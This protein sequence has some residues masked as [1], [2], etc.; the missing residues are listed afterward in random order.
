M[1]LIPDLNTTSGGPTNVA[2]VYERLSS[3]LGFN[4]RI[5]ETSTEKLNSIKS[6][7]LGDSVMLSHCIWDAY[8][9]IYFLR[10]KSRYVFS[11]GMLSKEAFR[12]VSIK[13]L[14][15]FRLYLLAIERLRVT[16][17][18]G[19]R[20]EFQQA[21]YKPRR[22]VILS[23]PVS[24]M[25]QSS[26][27]NVTHFR[28]GKVKFVYFSRFE[29]RKGLLE[30]LTAFHLLNSDN[31]EFHIIG[32]KSDIGYEQKIV[33]AAENM[34]NVF[35]HTGYS[36]EAA[37]KKMQC[38]DVICLWS[39]FEGQ[40]MSIIEGVADGLLPLVSSD[41]NLPFPT[42]D[43]FGFNSCKKSSDLSELME[44]FS[45]L[46][47]RQIEDVRKNYLTAINTSWQPNKDAQEFLMSL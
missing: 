26:D 33:A 44:Y 34:P 41:C 12:K 37:R 30:L 40:P 19:S 9:Y 7:N 4:T 1:Q 18:F 47:R 36:G 3:E 10:C 23:N 13:K 35:L 46:S 32:L 38:F 5:I 22:F 29:K 24:E 6:R 14:I 39:D 2:L 8:S 15:F 28:S 42:M 25:P 43:Y 11:H 31:S 45:R 20:E 21:I 17:I 27:A 16:I